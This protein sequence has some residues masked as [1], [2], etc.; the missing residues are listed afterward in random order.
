MM[1][2]TVYKNGKAVRL[3]S[4]IQDIIGSFKYEEDVKSEWNSRDDEKEKWE[5]KP[6]WAAEDYIELVR[7]NVA[8]CIIGK[9]VA[10]TNVYREN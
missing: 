4:W 3:I 2:E 6:S 10:F 8:G 9:S 1:W 5:V 7:R